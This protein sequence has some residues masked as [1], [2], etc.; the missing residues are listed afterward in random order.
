M[1]ITLANNPTGPAR[2]LMV[3]RGGLPQLSGSIAVQIRT[4]TTA[5]NTLEHPIQQRILLS[6]GNGDSRLWRNN[7]GTGWSGQATR[8]TAGN[9]RAVA[10]GL[11]PGDVVIRNGRPLHA[12]LCIGSAD[13]IGYRS[14]IITCQHVGRRV[15]VFAAVEVKGPRGRPTPEQTRF[16]EHITTAGGRAGIARSEA[17]ARMILDPA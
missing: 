3:Q 12:G 2:R 6:C 1:A 7:V 9:L 16:L 8:I 13:L 4:T 17:E 14:E 15:A 11:R 5:M 10:Q